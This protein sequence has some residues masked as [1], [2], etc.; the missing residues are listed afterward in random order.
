MKINLDFNNNFQ[1]ILSLVEVN[2]ALLARKDVTLH[3]IALNQ[4]QYK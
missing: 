1:L 2:K 4:L 3:L